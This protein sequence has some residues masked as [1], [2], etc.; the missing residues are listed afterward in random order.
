M[1]TKKEL[2]AAVEEVAEKLGVNGPEFLQR[3]REIMNDIERAREGLGEKN[4]G[5]AKAV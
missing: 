4:T 3:H 2:D 5:H 1:M